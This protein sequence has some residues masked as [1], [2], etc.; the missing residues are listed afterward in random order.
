MK[1]LVQKLVFANVQEITNLNTVPRIICIAEKR[2]E[3]YLDNIYLIQN[4]AWK[5]LYLNIH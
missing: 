3:L 2:S 5:Y 4:F 1:K